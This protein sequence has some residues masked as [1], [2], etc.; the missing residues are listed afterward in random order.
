MGKVK[1]RREM[2]KR[3]GEG[4]GGW[5]EKRRNKK[6]GVESP[7]PLHYAHTCVHRRG[8]EMRNAWQHATDA[9][10]R[11]RKKDIKIP[12]TS[13]EHLRT[14]KGVRKQ[15][16]ERRGKGNL[17]FLPLCAQASTRKRGRW[18]GSRR[19]F[20]PLTGACTRTREEME[21]A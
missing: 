19:K 15:E 16:K 13:R 3:E 9:R 14:C 8:G 10:E 11:G 21:K 1:R 18:R 6:K 7:S 5:R 17:L 4:N 2:E 20:L 12:Y